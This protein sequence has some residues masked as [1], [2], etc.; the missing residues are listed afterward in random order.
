MKY[1]YLLRHAKAEKTTTGQHDFDRMLL[2]S[3]HADA[4]MMGRKLRDLAVKPDLIISSMAIRAKQTA[5]LIAEQLKYK[6]TTI[7]YDEEIYESSVRILLRIIDMLENK[8]T[9]VM[10][11]GHDPTISYMA[12]HLTKEEIGNIPVCGV[13]KII[14]DITTWKEV[15]AGTGSLEWFKYPDSEE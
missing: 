14:F 13:V 9:N 1:L 3:G 12:E 4:H 7:L 5:E 10:I 11:I 6:L 2:R 15:S 8:Y